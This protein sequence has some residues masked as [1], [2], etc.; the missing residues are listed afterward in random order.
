MNKTHLNAPFEKGGIH[1]LDIQAHNEAIEIIWLKKYLENRLLWANIADMLIENSI[2]DS[3]KIDDNLAV[4][5]FFQWKP[6]LTHKSRLPPDLKRM[7]TV[8][9]T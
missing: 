8:F 4:N 5:M 1:I 9:F 3:S 6:C 7:I 2:A